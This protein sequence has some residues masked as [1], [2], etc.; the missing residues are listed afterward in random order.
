LFTYRGN[1]TN[2]SKFVQLTTEEVR[3]P[4]G[5]LSSSAL[6]GTRRFPITS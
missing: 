3:N 4:L 6:L 5:S 1:D 2:I